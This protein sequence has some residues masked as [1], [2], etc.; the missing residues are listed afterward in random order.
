M[1]PGDHS[2]LAELSEPGRQA[3]DRAAAVWVPRYGPVEVVEAW[4][5]SV[6]GI[7]SGAGEDYYDDYAIYLRWRDIIADMI[8]AVPQSDATT[9]SRIVD[10]I[11]AD[12]VAKTIDDAGKAMSRYHPGAVASGTWYW[13]RV[14]FRGPI[15]RSVGIETPLGP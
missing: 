4:R 1:A 9:I 7:T 8:A 12:F 10:P 13:Q 15:A 2:W 14:P 5:S 3:A 6:D 11:D